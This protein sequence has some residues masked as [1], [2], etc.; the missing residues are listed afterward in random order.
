MKIALYIFSL[1]VAFLGS[2][3]LLTIIGHSQNMGTVTDIDGNVY[4]TIKIGNKIWMKENLRSKRYLNGDSIPFISGNKKWSETTE[5]AWSYYN[6][7]TSQIRVYG[8][9]YNYYAV[10]NWR[11]ICPWG[12]HIPSEYEWQQLILELEGETRAGG[13]LKSKDG[14]KSPNTG[15][16]NSSR[17]SALPGGYRNPYGTYDNLGYNAAFWSATQRDEKT[18]WFYILNYNDTRI[19]KVGG[20]KN[21]GMSCRCVK[22]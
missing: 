11:G 21:Y 5:G 10:Y 17:F 8:L 1:L 13:K 2:N 19:N 4:N 6:N 9:L 7:D 12:W 3:Y 14:W 20:N 16:D 15:A 18:A 22:D